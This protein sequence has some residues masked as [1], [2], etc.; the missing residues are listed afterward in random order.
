MRSITALLITITLL[1]SLLI[2]V[3]VSFADSGDRPQLDVHAVTKQ[4]IKHD[5]EGRTD[6]LPIYLKVW[7]QERDW[8]SILSAAFKTVDLILALEPVN[9]INLL[10][11]ALSPRGVA[12]RLNSFYNSRLRTT[13]AEPFFS[14]TLIDPAKEIAFSSYLDSLPISQSPETLLVHYIRFAK[15]QLEEKGFTHQLS[16]FND[17]VPPSNRIGSI[18]PTTDKKNDYLILGSYK[19]LDP[20]AGPNEI[21]T[22]TE[23]YQSW[24]FKANGVTYDVCFNESALER[25]LP[26][27]D[28]NDIDNLPRSTETKVVPESVQDNDRGE[29]CYQLRE[30]IYQLTTAEQEEALSQSTQLFQDFP[31]IESLNPQLRLALR[32]AW[33]KGNTV[34]EKVTN[35]EEFWT[36]LL[37][38]TW[39]PEALY[40]EYFAHA[41]SDNAN[42]MRAICDVRAGSCLHHNFA[43]G[44]SIYQLS[45]GTI[46]VRFNSALRLSANTAVLESLIH[47]QVQYLDGGVWHNAEATYSDKESKQ[48]T[49]L[50]G[51]RVTGTPQAASHLRD[52]VKPSDSRISSKTPKELEKQMIEK[53]RVDNIPRPLRN[54]PQSFSEFV[55]EINAIDE[56]AGIAPGSFRSAIPVHKLP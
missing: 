15:K 53:K 32:T 26:D 50:F 3:Q 23:D 20:I 25:F 48:R 17:V 34:E 37:F 2:N 7:N 6:F 41:S 39:S 30:I 33:N 36:Q 11:S 18:K 16:N 5:L 9:A 45:G 8:H 40:K 10:E 12:T 27:L 13:V 44:V 19:N 38:Y 49:G 21:G 43:L 56:A 51:G 42:L 55:R 46:A 35:V 14:L 54:D 31:G 4:K 28:L 47:L 1:V 52:S 24:E 29:R 22:H